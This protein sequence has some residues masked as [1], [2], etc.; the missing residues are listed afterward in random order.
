METIPRDIDILKESQLHG[1]P[2]TYI[3]AWF[4]KGLPEWRKKNLVQ[5][6]ILERRMTDD[7]KL[8]TRALKVDEFPYLLSFYSGKYGFSIEE[9]IYDPKTN[10]L[11]VK[12]QN[13]S[14]VEKF[15][16]AESCIW[17]QS[18][19]GKPYYSRHQEYVIPN[20]GAKKCLQLLCGK[21]KTFE[22]GI[23]L[24]ER[25][26]T[27][28][29]DVQ[30]VH[31]HIRTV[32]KENRAKH[33]GGSLEMLE[34]A[35]EA[36]ILSIP[37]AEIAESKTN[38]LLQLKK[39][40]EES[41]EK[42]NNAKRFWS[43]KID[44]VEA[45]WQHSKEEGR[46]FRVDQPATAEEDHHYDQV[47]KNKFALF[48]SYKKGLIIPMMRNY[49]A[50]M[51]RQIEKMKSPRDHK[52]VDFL[53]CKNLTITSHY[54]DHLKTLRRTETQKMMFQVLRWQALPACLNL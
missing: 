46:L 30:E 51:L 40:K 23:K 28:S 24:L 47:R 7:N 5:Y 32:M 1:D 54:L 42:L 6:E 15:Y 39:L 13:A 4:L 3:H 35:I 26:I 10:S 17:K 50:E 2:Q 48:E 9:S 33:I 34:E 37:E 36:P 25:I 29:Q 31:A 16:V 21:D 22:E 41:K 12:T 19:E 44:R 45:W 20:R 14:L 38:L 18:E 49:K 53:R 8:Y 52:L 11:E 27:D 43:E